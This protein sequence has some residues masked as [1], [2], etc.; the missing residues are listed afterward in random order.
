M[1]PTLL[2]IEIDYS[3]PR[4]TVAQGNNTKD[5]RL[6]QV[7]ENYRFFIFKGG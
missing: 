6:H 1:P 7:G 3:M 2:P 4:T 5:G